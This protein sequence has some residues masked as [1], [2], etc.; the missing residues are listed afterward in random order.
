MKPTH[1]LHRGN[2]GLVSCQKAACGQRLEL[3]ENSNPR[4]ALE[5]RLSL[6]SRRCDPAFP[7]APSRKADSDFIAVQVELC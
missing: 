7:K 4:S 5:S 6:H 3:A 1:A 2:Y